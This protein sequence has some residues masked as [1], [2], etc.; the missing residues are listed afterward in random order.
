[1][2]EYA[3]RK[4]AYDR[5]WVDGEFAKVDTRGIGGTPIKIGH[6]LHRTGG[7][8]KVDDAVIDMTAQWKPTN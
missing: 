4:W 3:A 7:K 8:W 6:K 5:D 1:M 2:S